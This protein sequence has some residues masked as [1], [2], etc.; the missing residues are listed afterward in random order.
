MLNRVHIKK[1][2][3]KDIFFNIE[4]SEFEYDEFNLKNSNIKMLEKLI[5]IRLIKE[6]VKHE[7]I[8]VFV[9]LEVLV[10]VYLESYFD[11]F[12]NET[13]LTKEV[14]N[15]ILENK[16]CLRKNLNINL[17]EIPLKYLVECELLIND[18]ILSNE[19]VKI[20]YGEN[21]YPINKTDIYE[22]S[23]ENINYVNMI[24]DYINKLYNLQKE[25]NI[26]IQPIQKCNSRLKI[27]NFKNLLSK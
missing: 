15:K 9:C 3:D 5:D 19:V 20:K 4:T 21:I 18:S 24:N 23:L 22:Y 25:F 27:F 10:P 6:K 12:N 11:N 7:T 17:T 13:F 1:Y 14:I 16:D 8:K 26:L 2:G